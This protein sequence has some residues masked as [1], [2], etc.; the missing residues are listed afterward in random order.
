[1]NS[2]LNVPDPEFSFQTTRDELTLWLI[3]TSDKVAF[4]VGWRNLFLVDAVVR[5]LKEIE[6]RHRT[7]LIPNTNLTTFFVLANTNYICGEEIIPLV[8]LL[9]VTHAKELHLLVVDC[10]EEVLFWLDEDDVFHVFR[11][12]IENA[13]WSHMLKCIVSV[14]Y[15]HILVLSK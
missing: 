10:E 7:V 8:R 11:F 5:I 13:A 1:M 9:K 15:D 3:K 12:K 14:K 4:P 2:S 6:Q